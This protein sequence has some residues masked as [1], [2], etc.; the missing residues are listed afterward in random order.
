MSEYTIVNLR[1][2]E[3]SAVK[4][5]YSPDLSA[6]FASGEL[7]L[8]KSGISLQRLAPNTRTPFGHREPEQEELYVVVDGGGRIKLDDEVV[9]LRRWDAIRVPPGVARQTEAG[10]DGIE[11]L[12]FGAPRTGEPSNKAEALPGWWDD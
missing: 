10:P 11:L 9:E 2:V 8:E 5:G 6:R 1:E 3:D 12:A 4:F 7:G